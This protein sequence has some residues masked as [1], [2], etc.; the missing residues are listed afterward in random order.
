M[1]NARLPVVPA[2]CA[3]FTI[4]GQLAAQVP[5]ASQVV[6][7][8]TRNNA[9]GGTFMPGNALGAPRGGGSSSGSADIHSLGVDGHLTLGFSVTIVDGPGADFLVAENPFHTGPGQVYAELMYVEVS[10]NGND[11]ARFPARFFGGDG[12]PF[13]INTVGFVSG[14]AGQTPVFTNPASPQLDPQDV[15]EAG[16]DAFDLHDLRSHPLVISGAVDLHHIAQ[17]R[18]VDVVSGQSLD[19][20]GRVILDPSSGSADVDAVTVIHHTGNLGGHGPEVALDVPP[21]GNFALT[22]ADPDGLADLDPA[23]LRLSLFGQPVDPVP[24]LA[25]MTLR[26][27]TATSVRLEL[28]GPLPPGWLLQIGVSVKDRAGARSGDLRQRPIN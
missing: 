27:L 12:S 25:V 19:A 4:P 24:V 17:V 2:L 8:D 5:F 11:F 6:A 7:F 21:D 9:G 23:S 22:I 13:A 15:V 20:R 3:L 14:L 26:H 10:S 28:G 1:R 18:L 16:G